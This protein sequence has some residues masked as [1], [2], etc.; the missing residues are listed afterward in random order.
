MTERAVLY[1]DG[2]LAD[3]RSADL[4]VGVSVLVTDD[5][6][7]WIR[8]A[9]DEGELL[10]DCQVI[11]AGGSTIVPGMVDGHSHLSL[12]GGS[13]WIDRGSDPTEVLL[14]S[15]GGERRAAAPLRSPLGQGRRLAP[16]AGG[17]P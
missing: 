17:W 6:I 14:R 15:R 9:G 5:R 8:P 16:T 4:R 11:D 1:R 12:P 2:A 13:H 10:A 3:G 7:S